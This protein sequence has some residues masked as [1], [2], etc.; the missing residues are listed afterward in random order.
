MW[1]KKYIS[2]FIPSLF[3]EYGLPVDAFLDSL[4]I[5][6]KGHLLQKEEY[7]FKEFKIQRTYSYTNGLIEAIEITAEQNKSSK[8][9]YEY[10]KYLVHQ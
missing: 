3:L 7:F 9:Y 8:K 10:F 5:N 4:N 6:A 1:Q 2:A